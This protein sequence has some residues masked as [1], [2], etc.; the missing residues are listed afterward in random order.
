MAECLACGGTGYDSAARR[1]GML[2]GNFPSHMVPLGV[3]SC[4]SCNG[5]GKRWEPPVFTEEGKAEL[6]AC[7]DKA[8]A[9][10]GRFANRK[11]LLDNAD[12]TLM[13]ANS[14]ED[15]SNGD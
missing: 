1:A 11:P 4:D 13:A 9:K 12:D 8:L 6:K 2:G 3:W 10:A 5:T 15:A 7:V 14:T